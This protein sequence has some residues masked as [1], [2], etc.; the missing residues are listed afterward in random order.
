MSSITESV[1]PEKVTPLTVEKSQAFPP[2]SF[3]SRL[4]HPDL[5]ANFRILYQDDDFVAIDKPAGFHVHAPEDEAHAVPKSV[6]AMALLR[7]QLG[8]Y[9]Y[10]AHRIDRATSGVVLYALTPE[11]CG[12]LG[13]L[14]AARAVEKSYYAVV[15]G[16]TPEAGVIDS[17]MTTSL[18]SQADPVPS[19]TRYV[20]LHRFELPFETARFKTSRYSLL[21]AIPETGRLHQ[22]RR[23]LRRL[24]Y[25]IIGDT[26]HGDG[27]HNRYF[28]ALFGRPYLYLKAYRVSF[29]HP[30]TGERIEIRARWNSAWHRLFEEAGFCPWTPSSVGSKTDPS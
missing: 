6:N 17:P 21:E 19:L 15:R 14:F 28:R 30:R 11:F 4:V 29:S 10:P 24:S 5:M 25:P 23:H 8:R 9:V 7:D 20:R 3:F 26:V 18:T 16:W 22:I 13:E 12:R 27:E 2:G 1:Y